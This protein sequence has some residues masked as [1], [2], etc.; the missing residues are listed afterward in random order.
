MGS[1]RSLSILELLADLENAEDDEAAEEKGQHVTGSV[2][3]SQGVERR[4]FCNILLFSVFVGILEDQ[5]A[6]S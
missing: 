2:K 4:A 5:Y 6:L 3:N 1:N